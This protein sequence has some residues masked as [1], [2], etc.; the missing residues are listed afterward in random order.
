MIEERELTRLLGRL[1]ETYEPPAF[2]RAAI[3]EAASED[4]PVK[5]VKPLPAVRMSRRPHRVLSVAAVVGVLVGGAAVVGGLGRSEPQGLDSIASTAARVVSSERS[6]SAVSTT[7]PAADSGAGGK[8]ANGPY[9]PSV[10]TVPPV[11]PVS[12]TVVAGRTPD[13]GVRV[14]RTARLDLEVGKG[15]FGDALDRLTALAVDRGGFVAQ[16][17]TSEGD[18]APSGTVTLRIPGAELDA[19]ITQVRMLGRILSVSTRGE[20]VTAQY[21]DIEA[22]LRGLTASRDQI[23]TVLSKAGSVGEILAV[24]ERL[25]AV[26]VQ[27]E[28]LQGQQKLLDDQT[29]LGTVAVHLSEPGGAR[30]NGPKTGL[31]GAWEDARHGFTRGLEA[32]VSG[33]GTALLLA[34]SLAAVAFA[35]R[36]AWHLAR[37]RLV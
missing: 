15:R 19:V 36:G 30:P 5:P 6:R 27:I 10:S 22:R 9:L 28:Q 8:Y 32:I 21:S 3:L 1:A 20:D 35:G 26:Q 13:S 25:N 4:K 24:Q 7:V 33:S 37:R 11:G 14:I 17:E 12:R 16:A 18:A 29:T 34:L 2:G 23:L 31:A